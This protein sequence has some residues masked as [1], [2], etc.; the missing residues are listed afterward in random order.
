MPELNDK[1]LKSLGRP[2]RKGSGGIESP[3]S[4]IYPSMNLKAAVMP[5]LGKSAFGDTGMMV[6]EYK[7]TG[8]NSY[9]DGDID[10]SLDITKGKLVGYKKEK[11]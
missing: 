8:I 4:P 3:S 2:I 5:G 6:V 7:V 1:D 10:I 11:K 9:G